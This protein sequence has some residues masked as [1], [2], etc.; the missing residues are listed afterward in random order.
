MGTK[1]LKDKPEASTTM[2]SPVAG[3]DLQNFIKY[4]LGYIKLTREKTV[5]AQLCHSIELPKEYFDI[6]GLLNSDF[7]AEFID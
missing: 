4:C 1:T 5:A 7:D 6:K 3:G 2:E